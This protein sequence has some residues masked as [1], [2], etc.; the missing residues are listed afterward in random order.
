MKMCQPKNLVVPRPYNKS[1][2]ADL[3]FDNDLEALVRSGGFMVKYVKSR[4]APTRSTDD[5]IDR[6]KNHC[7]FT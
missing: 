4:K 2:V 3:A 5:P 7:H 6:M 1:G